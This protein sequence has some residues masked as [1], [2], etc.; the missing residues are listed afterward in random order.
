MNKGIIF[1]NG[2]LDLAVAQCGI[3]VDVVPIATDQK[4]VDAGRLNLVLQGGDGSVVQAAGTE[5]ELH[6]GE[7]FGLD[8]LQVG[9]GM[10]S[11]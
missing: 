1:F 7:A 11:F 3:G 6:A 9:V 5:L 10:L 4:G 2:L 8:E